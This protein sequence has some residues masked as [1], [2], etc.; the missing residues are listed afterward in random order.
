MARGKK[1][2]AAMMSGR[3]LVGRARRAFGD[4][5]PPSAMMGRINRSILE[6]SLRR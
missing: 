1:T 5:A 6:A 4:E 2:P 3:E